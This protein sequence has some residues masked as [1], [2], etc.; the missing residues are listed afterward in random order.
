MDNKTKNTVLSKTRLIYGLL[1]ILEY[2]IDNLKNDVTYGEATD[3]SRT[4]DEINDTLDNLIDVIAEIEY[5]LYL[6]GLTRN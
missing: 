3:I 5:I 6:N 2:D 1:N 4:V